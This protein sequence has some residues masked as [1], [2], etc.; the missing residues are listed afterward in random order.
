M[1]SRLNVLST[2]SF[3]GCSNLVSVDAPYVTDIQESAFADAFWLSTANCPRVHNIGA[4]AFRSAGIEYSSG[5]S[6]PNVNDYR[7]FSLILSG[8]SANNI[9]TVNN[10]S[11]EHSRV[12][13]HLS[14]NDVKAAFLEN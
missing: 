3:C 1:D 14:S 6:N 5:E 4:Y 12:A 9:P 10:H 8:A 11:F 7:G 13:V 2:C